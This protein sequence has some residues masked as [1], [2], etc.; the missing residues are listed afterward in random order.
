MKLGSWL[1]LAKRFLE[2]L[3]ARPLDDGLREEAELLLQSEGERALFFGQPH[4]DQRHGIAAA[5]L[6]EGRGGLRRAALLHDV[7]KQ[8]SGLGVWGRSLASV[9]AKLHLPVA[10]RFRTYLEHGPIGALM[11]EEV[12]AEALVVAF[13]RHHHGPQP[14]AFADDDWQVLQRADRKAQTLFSMA[15]R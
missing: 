9:L 12:G 3:T 13:A 7:G 5:R 4:A 11:L 6:V 1:H 14:P 2:V 15:I 8:R 10:G